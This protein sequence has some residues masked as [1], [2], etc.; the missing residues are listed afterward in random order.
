LFQRDRLAGGGLGGDFMDLSQ[1]LQVVQLMAT[2]T[3]AYFATRIAWRQ[4]NTARDKLKLDLYEK[5]F[6]VYQALLTFLE[7]ILREGKVTAEFISAFNSS[8]VGKEF[9]FNNDV[10]EY[11]KEVKN[12]A[13]EWRTAC[14]KIK[15]LQP[16]DGFEAEQKEANDTDHKLLKWLSDQPSQAPSVF[17]SYLDF[18]K[19]L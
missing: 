10:N 13:M 5:R 6:R 2:L 3:V 18:R 9:L 19:N 8:T 12:K 7:A 4:A 15:S 11:L 16:K 14:D 17:A 1:L